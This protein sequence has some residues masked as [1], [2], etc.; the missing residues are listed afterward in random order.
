MKHSADLRLKD[1]C[2]RTAAHWATICGHT[3]A[4]QALL[5]ND[6]ID[7]NDVD[8]AGYSCLLYACEHGHSDIV[9]MFLSIERIE[10]NRENAIGYTAA[11]LAKWYGHKEIFRKL[12]EKSLSE[13]KGTKNL[14]T[15]SDIRTAVEQNPKASE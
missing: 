4:V 3:S 6:E 11:A 12:Q 9:E 7:P 2:G 15:T 5:T 13:G 10:L 14:K 8:A 1:S